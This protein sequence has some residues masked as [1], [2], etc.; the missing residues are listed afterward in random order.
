[1]SRRFVAILLAVSILASA[2]SAVITYGAI[3]AF[4]GGPK[5]EQG[6]QG[7]QGPQGLQGIRGDAG[8][9]AAGN[10]KYITTALAALLLQLKDPSRTVKF[11]D[12][13]AKACAAWLTDGTGSLTEC[14]FDR[15][16]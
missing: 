1:M 3:Q 13:D 2:Q 7:F 5:G 9:S 10:T 12:S 14:G 15:V 6:P 4:G 8:T 11:S 16:P